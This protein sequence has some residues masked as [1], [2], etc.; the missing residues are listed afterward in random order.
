M[1]KPR[2]RMTTAAV[3]F[4]TLGATGAAHAGF[5]GP[6]YYAGVFA[7]N[8]SGSG[9]SQDAVNTTYDIPTASS[10]TMGLLGGV[11]F[12]NGPWLLGGE[13]D[14]GLGSNRTVSD[15]QPVVSEIKTNLHL[16]GRFG[17]QVNN[18]DLFLTGGYVQIQVSGNTYPGTPTTTLGGY[19]IGA[20]ADYTV[21]QNIDVR[22]QVLQDEYGHED[23]GNGYSIKDWSDTSIRA[24]AIFQF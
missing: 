4:G 2:K 16:L 10:G 5:G 6:R 12:R 14:L 22:L 18:I 8:I 23:F 7:G 17:Y 24:A 15:S 19:S 1:R 11:N 3:L 9:S 21:A 20:G 13:V